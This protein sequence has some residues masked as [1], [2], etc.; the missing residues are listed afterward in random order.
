LRTTTTP[1][2]P[3]DGNAAASSSASAKYTDTLFFSNFPVIFHVHFFYWIKLGQGQG[4]GE[5]QIETTASIRSR[6]SF[7]FAAV[8][9][10]FEIVDQ[11]SGPSL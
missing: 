8:R 11:Q 4:K 6:L 3:R 9:R 10:L 7:E 2:H 1:I 5:E